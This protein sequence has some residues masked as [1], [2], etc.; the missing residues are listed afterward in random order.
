MP[1]PSYKAILHH[2]KAKAEGVRVYFEELPHLLNDDY[3]YEVSLAYLFLRT[4]RAQNKALYCGAVK[5]HRVSAEVATRAIDTQHLTRDGFL[6]LYTNVFGEELP[7]VVRDKIKVAERIRDRVVHGKT[8]SDA[9]MREAHVDVLDYAE[10]LNAEL[11]RVGGFEPFGDL[12][13]FKG[14]A[15]A[16]D[17]ATSRWLLKGLGF[18]IA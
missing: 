8:V 9:E 16:L 6:G 11:L 18:A 17:N 4:E 10:A 2:Y 15:G 13:G 5:L 7:K 1:A 12:R 3:T 14:R